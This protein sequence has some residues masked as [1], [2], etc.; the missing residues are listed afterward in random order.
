MLFTRAINNWQDKL[1]SHQNQ[2]TNSHSQSGS[3][4]FISIWLCSLTN[5]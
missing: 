2:K 4:L 1:H 3:Q 5:F